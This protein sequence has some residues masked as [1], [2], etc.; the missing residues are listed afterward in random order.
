MSVAGEETLERED[1]VCIEET[2]AA[3]GTV[4]WR[5]RTRVARKIYCGCMDGDECDA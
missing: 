5:C 3:R 1:D 2:G 4:R